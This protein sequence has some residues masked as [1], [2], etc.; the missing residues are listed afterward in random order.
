VSLRAPGW[1]SALA[2]AEALDD[3]ESPSAQALRPAARE[4]LRVLGIEQGADRDGNVIASAPDD[5]VVTEVLVREGQTVTAG[6]PLFRINGT[7]TLW[8]EAAI[9]QA[10]A[11]ALAPGSAVEANLEAFPGERFHGSVETLL[12]QVEGSS[13][14]QRARIVLHNADGRLAPGMLAEV[15]LQAEAGS[16]VPLVP[17]EALILTGDDSRVIV[18]DEDDAFR[19]V[20]VRV[21][22]S[23]GGRTEILSGLAGDER[24]VVSGQFLIDSEASLAGALERLG[25]TGD[26]RPDGAH[27]HEHS[28]PAR[29]EGEP[30]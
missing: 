18:A 26:V 23:G 3:A 15:V 1:V 10:L 30:Q 4:R 14:T 22:R 11:G 21:G 28:A 24:I 27:G 17:T 12:P 16:P 13:R 6:V 20:R 9:P 8:L 5:G 7:G 29:A 2:E 25:A 19:P